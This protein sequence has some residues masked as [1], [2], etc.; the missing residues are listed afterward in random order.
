MLYTSNTSSIVLQHRRIFTPLLCYNNP[1]HL[2]RISANPS[3]LAQEHYSKE[4][5]VKSWRPCC[6][7]P[8]ILCLYA[9]DSTS[10]RMSTQAKAFYEIHTAQWQGIQTLPVLVCQVAK[11]T[12][13][14]RGFPVQE[15]PTS[16][17]HKP[18]GPKGYS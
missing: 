11:C 2:H 8:G 17:H 5:P 14:M 3:L 15:Q 16:T 9:Q 1:I 7:P 6:S 12:L 4:T 13:P 18:P 10:T